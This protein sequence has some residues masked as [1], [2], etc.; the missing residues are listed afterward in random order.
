MKKLLCLLLAL[1]C[2]MA[3]VSCNLGGG[4]S[5]DEEEAKEATVET[6]AGI[7]NASNPTQIATKV[8]YVEEGE[9][10]ITSS[11]N[12]EK[13]EVNGIYK[14]TFSSARKA[15]VEELLPTDVKVLE[16][17]VWY[18]ADGTVTSS[19]GDEWS[20]EDA[21]GYLPEMININ[22]SSFKS[23]ELVND[24]DDLV[25]VIAA[26]DAKRV[27]GEDIAA[28][29]DISVEI[30]TNGTYLYKITVTYTTNQGATVTIT[31]SYDYAVIDLKTA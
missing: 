15:S 4:S 12:T 7:I 2:V 20:K 14:F 23:Y 6:I 25:G 21:V 10:H 18:N 5:E 11:Y 1:M 27:F 13:D 30:D 31:T 16:G 22:K 17:T 29:S 8:D 9:D 26:N 24:G 19:T 3:C 28:S